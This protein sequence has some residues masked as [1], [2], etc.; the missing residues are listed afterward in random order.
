MKKLKIVAGMIITLL[1]VTACAP[2]H[3][4]NN[5]GTTTQAN[6]LPAG[7]PHYSSGNCSISEAPYATVFTVISGGTAECIQLE[8]VFNLQAVPNSYG[9]ALGLN[10]TVSFGG[11]MVQ[12]RGADF[13]NR[14]CDWF[15][16]RGWQMTWPGSSATPEPV[17]PPAPSELP[18]PSI[19]STTGSPL[20]LTCQLAYNVPQS[21]PIGPGNGTGVEGWVTPGADG[22]TAW[23]GTFYASPPA[24]WQAGVQI[25]STQVYPWNTPQPAAGYSITI[26]L[27]NAAGIQVYTTSKIV[28]VPPSQLSD[29]TGLPLFRDIAIGS[30][31]AGADKCS[32]VVN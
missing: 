11:D 31:A 26:T 19:Y 5:T 15:G 1:V 20:I 3:A 10:C 27:T 2:N 9:T 7:P 12:I 28:R 8:Q 30:N 16:A 29:T 17:T 13:A 25:D 14:F 23:L 22:E 4:S 21:N 24:G 18:P 32:A 6:T